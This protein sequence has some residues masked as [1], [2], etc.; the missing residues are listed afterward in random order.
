MTKKMMHLGALVSGAGSH[1]GGWR[2]PEAEFGAMNF[3]HIQRTVQTAERGKFDFAF[4]ADAVAT[5][6]SLAP[7]FIVR[8]EP[9][10]M[11]SAL[12]MTTSHIGLVATVSTTYSQPYNVARLLGSVDHLSKGRAGWNVV[13]STDNGSAENFGHEPHPDHSLRYDRAEE[14][15]A[16]VQKLWDSVEDDAVVGDKESGVYVD[17]D[18]MHDIDFQGKFY[19]VKGPLN[20]VRPPQGYP[21]TF[22]AGA[23]DRGIAFAGATA[24][25]IFTAQQT[26]EEALEFG[27]KVREAAEA[28]GRSRDSVRILCGVCPIVG[29]TREEALSIVS[30]LGEL[31]DPEA[32]MR[33]LIDRI[34]YDLNQYPLDEPLPDLELV[35]SGS[36]GHARQL[37]S[38]VKREKLTLRQLRDVGAMSSGHRLLLGTAEEIADDLESW[39]ASGAADGFAILN[40]YLPQPLE[41]FV[42][43]VVPILTKRGLF[44]GDYENATLRGHL[45]LPL[46]SSSLHTQLL[47]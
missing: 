26:Q 43:E 21:V 19:S 47:G 11:L 17:T 4:F 14:Y 9:I 46:P 35:S 31:T 5:N 39:F 38:L 13:T 45:G 2:M 16:V 29:S 37:I 24:E 25:V 33:T 3:E 15:V 10:T 30:R 41:R 27:R 1:V 44:R 42:D 40:P 22:Q 36:V 34:G 32:A 18:K 8:L 12:S 23:S 28:A 6:R 20:M 7:T